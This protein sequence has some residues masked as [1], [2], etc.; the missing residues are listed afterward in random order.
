MS[1]K[2]FQFVFCVV[3]G[4][5]IVNAM[6]QDHVIHHAYQEIGKGGV[7]TCGS[8][9]SNKVDWIFRG[10]RFKGRYMALLKFN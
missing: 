5:S 1:S 6:Q 4:V 7:L 8:L 9:R 10:S 3:F 2:A